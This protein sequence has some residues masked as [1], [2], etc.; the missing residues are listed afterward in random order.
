MNLVEIIFRVVWIS[1]MIGSSFILGLRHKFFRRA[2]H[3][4]RESMLVTDGA[5]ALRDLVVGDVLEVPRCEKVHS[6]G[7]GNAHM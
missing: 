7:R 3:G 4:T 6:V 1:A 5:D 2:N